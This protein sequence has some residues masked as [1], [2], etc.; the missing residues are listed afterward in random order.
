MKDSKHMLGSQKHLP[1]MKEKKS[2]PGN[3]AMGRSRQKEEKKSKSKQYIDETEELFF[4]FTKKTKKTQGVASPS[5]QMRSSSIGSSSA[6]SKPA[7]KSVLSPRN[8]KVKG[9]PKTPKSPP[10]RRNIGEQ[11]YF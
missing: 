6:K 9:T 3:A 11:Y 4:C 8:L 10:K 7:K 5:S 2:P 1:K